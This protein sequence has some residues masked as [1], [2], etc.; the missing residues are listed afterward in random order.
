[1]APSPKGMKTCLGPCKFSWRLARDDCPQAKIHIFLS[2]LPRGLLSNAIHM[3]IFRKLPSSWFLCKHSLCRHAVSVRVSVTFVYVVKTNKHTFNTFSP[4]GS[5][6]ILVFP[7]QTAQQY[8]D[9]N[10]LTRALNARGVD[11]NRHSTPI[12]GFTTCC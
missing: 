12:S 2:G 9:G 8:S 5:H 1:M 7:H 11:R 10:T 4:P 6:T 3:Y